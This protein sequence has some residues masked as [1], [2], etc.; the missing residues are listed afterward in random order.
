MFI[1]LNTSKKFDAEQ[2]IT[3]KKIKQR[4]KQSNMKKRSTYQHSTETSPVP[5]NYVHHNPLPIYVRSAFPNMPWV[6][7]FRI[8]G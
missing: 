8:L 3:N 7:Y 5:P 1:Y 4:N 6:E 2:I